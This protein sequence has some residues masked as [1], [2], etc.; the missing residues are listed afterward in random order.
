MYFYANGN[1]YEGDFIDGKYEG[2]GKY[3]YKNGDMFEG[4]F[5]DGKSVK[6]KQIN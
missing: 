3:Y 6:L 5:K 4:V 1:R 2:K